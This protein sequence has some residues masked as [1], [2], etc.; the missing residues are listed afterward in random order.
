[1]RKAAYIVK[2]LDD[3]HPRSRSSYYEFDG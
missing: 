3:S 2:A 1:V